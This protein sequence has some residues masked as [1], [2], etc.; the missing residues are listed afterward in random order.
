MLQCSTIFIQ[1]PFYGQV[2]SGELPDKGEA[3]NSGVEEGEEVLPPWGE[4]SGD[5]PSGTAE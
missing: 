1:D 4:L 3:Q 2:V 5:I